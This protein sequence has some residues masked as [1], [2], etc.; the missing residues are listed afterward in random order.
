MKWIIE[1]PIVCYKMKR[2]NAEKNGLNCFLC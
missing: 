1:Y 2:A